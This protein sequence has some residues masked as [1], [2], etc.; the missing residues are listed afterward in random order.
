[1]N[2]YFLVMLFFCLSFLSIFRWVKQEKEFT[3][4]AQAPDSA[5]KLDLGFKEGQ[6]IT[7]NIGVPSLFMR[8]D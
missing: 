3:K 8:Y 4:Q 5:P 7:L 2:D 1:M 6:T